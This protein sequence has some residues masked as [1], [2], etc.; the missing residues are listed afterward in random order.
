[1]A[2]RQATLRLRGRS[3]ENAQ[4]RRYNGRILLFLSL[5]HRGSGKDKSLRD[6]YLD[7]TVSRMVVVKK[8]PFV[9]SVKGVG[10]VDAGD[11]EEKVD[12]I[13]VEEKEDVAE[14]EDNVESSAGGATMDEEEKV[15]DVVPDGKKAGALGG[16]SRHHTGY[17]EF[18]GR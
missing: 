11:V 14:E 5:Q 15:A 13:R 10:N 12:A 16:D 7:W 4:G 17:H 8:D 9:E 2:G 3:Y 18:K 1:M 6:T